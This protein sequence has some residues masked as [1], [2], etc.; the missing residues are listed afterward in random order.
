MVESLLN[1]FVGVGS[2]KVTP[3]LL[4]SCNFHQIF[5]NT[6]VVENLETKT[7]ENEVLVKD[8]FREWEHY[9][10]AYNGNSWG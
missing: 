5:K 7:S 1:K 2:W 10:V 8:F 6:Y 3:G 9:L 4:F